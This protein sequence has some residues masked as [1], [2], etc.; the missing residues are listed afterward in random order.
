MF[1]FFK[2]VIYLNFLLITLLFVRL[3]IQFKS[4]GISS[5][6]AREIL[7]FYI[8]TYAYYVYKI[9]LN[10]SERYY[11]F[12]NV[13]LPLLFA[14]TWI[15]PSKKIFFFNLTIYFFCGLIIYFMHNRYLIFAIY[16]IG[17]LNIVHKSLYLAKQ[18]R[19]IRLLAMVYINLSLAQLLSFANF[20]MHEI[21]FNWKSSIYLKYYSFLPLI[22]YPTL[23]IFT[24][25][26]FRRL[27]HI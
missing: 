4:I 17:L 2:I 23:T 5:F 13:F 20:I 27:F 22:I 10:G 16:I 25:V 18:N 19:K 8:L 21:E 26:N 14:M 11:D 9:L 24:H 12:L 7:L 6:Y 3:I 15:Y 1:I